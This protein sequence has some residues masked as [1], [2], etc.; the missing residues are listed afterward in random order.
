MA[1][2]ILLMGWI[3]LFHAS[4]RAP[5]PFGVLDVGDFEA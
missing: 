2:T 4:A 1:R 3:M 5:G